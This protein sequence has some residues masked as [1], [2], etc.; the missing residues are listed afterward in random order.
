MSKAQW[1]H[2][3]YTACQNREGPYFAI[4]EGAQDAVIHILHQASGMPGHDT[5]DEIKLGTILAVDSW[6]DRNKDE[7]IDAIAQRL[8]SKGDA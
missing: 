4:R 5:F 6:L 2:G 3:F 7:L 1:G 8:I